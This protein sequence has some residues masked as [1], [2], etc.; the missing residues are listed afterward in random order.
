MSQQHIFSVK[1][2][3]IQKF[4]QILADCYS[5]YSL[6]TNKMEELIEY[7]KQ[8]D[9]AWD[10]SLKELQRLYEEDRMIDATISPCG[11]YE[12]RF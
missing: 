9:V 10:L 5:D 12:P 2:D 11:N 3:Q 8:I 6:I 1:K 7:K 4:K